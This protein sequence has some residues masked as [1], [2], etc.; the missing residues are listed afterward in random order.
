ML[1]VPVVL[2]RYGGSSYGT[3]DRSTHTEGAF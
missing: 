1:P 3:E 2:E